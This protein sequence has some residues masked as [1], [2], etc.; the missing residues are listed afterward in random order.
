MMPIIRLGGGGGGGF[1]GERPPQLNLALIPLCIFR[2]LEAGTDMGAC[3]GT[4]DCSFYKT[5]CGKATTSTSRAY[6]CFGAPAVCRAAGN[7]K[8]ANCVRLCLQ[9]DDGCLNIPDK[10]FPGCEARNHAFCFAF[11]GVACRL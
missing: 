1:G 5:Q 8:L 4:T 9:E 6:Y 2:A 7:T 3:Q 10:D 11:C